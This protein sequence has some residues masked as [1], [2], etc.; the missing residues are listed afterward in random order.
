MWKGPFRPSVVALAIEL[1]LGL[2]EFLKNKVAIEF[3]W[4]K[5]D[6]YESFSTVLV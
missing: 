2:C 6:Q 3:P 4:T 5:P 1:E